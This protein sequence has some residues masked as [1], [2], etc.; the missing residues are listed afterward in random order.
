ML[1]NA[2]FFLFLCVNP[3]GKT[4]QKS[5]I[6][7]NCPAQAFH[8][9]QIAPYNHDNHARIDPSPGCLARRKCKYCSGSIILP[10][11]YSFAAEG[12]TRLKVN[13]STEHA[14]AFIRARVAA[15]AVAPVV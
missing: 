13:T 6:P 4:N 9:D 10:V 5:F 12:N 14:P 8:I 3:S 11:P 15:F 7:A 1:K 2:L